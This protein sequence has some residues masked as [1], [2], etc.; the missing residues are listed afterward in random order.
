MS[1]QEGYLVRVSGFLAVRNF[2]PGWIP[3]P[4]FFGVPVDQA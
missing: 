3:R 4:Q 2:R 1:G